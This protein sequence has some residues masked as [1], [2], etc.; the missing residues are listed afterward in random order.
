MWKL[1]PDV[2]LAP[3][4]R[5]LRPAARRDALVALAVVL[6]ISAGFA[7]LVYDAVAPRWCAPAH[8][9]LWIATD[10]EALGIRIQTAFDA[11]SELEEFHRNACDTIGAPVPDPVIVQVRPYADAEALRARIRAGDGVGVYAIPDSALNPPYAD[12]HLWESHPGNLTYGEPYVEQAILDAR[13]RR[14]GLAP[15]PAKWSESHLVDLYW[16]VLDITVSVAGIPVGAVAVFVAGAQLAGGLSTH[17]RHVG[18]HTERLVGET[19]AAALLTFAWAFTLSMF[20]VLV[21]A[22]LGLRVSTESALAAIGW[23]AA[24]GGCGSLWIATLLSMRT[25]APALPFLALC[26]STLANVTRMS[27]LGLE[28][29]LLTAGLSWLLAA[30]PPLTLPRWS[31][32]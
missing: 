26:A 11:P 12:D 18:E 5:A 13:R 14:A 32:L 17:G 8:G 27:S 20:A 19:L 21:G 7:R 30:I 3:T 29:V 4:H 1:R 15:E 24:V 25:W 2:L 23:I 31:R 9:P 28:L 16:G 22:S 6:A 10:D